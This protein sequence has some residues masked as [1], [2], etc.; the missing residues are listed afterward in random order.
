MATTAVGDPVLDEMVRR[1]VSG[2]DPVRII[3]FGSRARG[4]H[5]PDSDYDLLVILDEVPSKHDARVEIRRVLSDV[6]AAKDILVLSEA[7][8]RQ[9]QPCGRVSRVA[10]REGVPVHERSRAG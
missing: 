3:L 2:F 6:H 8:S 1:I 7:E 4:D 10:L 9:Y 5:R